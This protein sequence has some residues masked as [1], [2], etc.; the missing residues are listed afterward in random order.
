MGRDLIRSFL[1]LSNEE[2]QPNLG[3][4]EAALAFYARKRTKN[5][6]GS[7]RTWFNRG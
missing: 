4:A 2:T 5:K 7:G 1:G 6:K 3:S